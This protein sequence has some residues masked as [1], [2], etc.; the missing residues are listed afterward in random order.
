MARPGAA[1]PPTA[2]A[3]IYAVVRRIPRGRV[4]TYGR[5]A[6]LAGLPRAPRV[7]GYA[8][9]ALPAGSPLPWHRVVAAGGRLSVAR[10]SP[11]SALTQRLRLERE[12]VAFDARGRVVL[13]AHEWN[14]RAASSAGAVRRRAR[15]R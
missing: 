1:A 2:Y 9:Y 6:A 7:A 13:A 5:V 12:G 11:D 3:R 10:V 8:L 14:G 4:A 15:K